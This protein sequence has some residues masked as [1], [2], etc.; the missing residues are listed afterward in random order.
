[1]SSDRV[2]RLMILV[3]S[4]LVISLI[5]IGSLVVYNSSGR[6]CETHGIVVGSRY[7]EGL[8]TSTQ[9]QVEEGLSVPTT[10]QYP[11]N[12]VLEV[13]SPVLGRKE[14][15]WPER[16]PAGR[17]VYLEYVIGRLSREPEVVVLRLQRR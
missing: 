8:T 6:V 4:A 13:D 7:E 2:S 14:I 16:L 12:W 1:M 17:E 3:L 5:G 11:G 10:T 15:A 9:I